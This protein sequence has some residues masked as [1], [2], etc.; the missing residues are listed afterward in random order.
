LVLNVF[1]AY[2]PQLL[3]V[4]LGI[5]IVKLI[6]MYKLADL[7]N[8]IL[9]LLPFVLLISH[10]FQE[11]NIDR[12][13][14][15]YQIGWDV[16]RVIHHLPLLNRSLKIFLPVLHF[17]A[18]EVD[19]SIFISDF[20]KF[21]IANNEAVPGHL[22]NVYLLAYQAGQLAGCLMFPFVRR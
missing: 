11:F 17:I 1:I 16:N 4:V 2:F 19:K 3:G 21:L 5:F 20:D 18:I 10:N 7:C 12:E 8:D 22:E 15:D 14:A 6:E 9:M 13:R